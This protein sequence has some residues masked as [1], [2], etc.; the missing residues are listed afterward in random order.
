MKGER[1]KIG[2]DP[3]RGVAVAIDGRIT[4][5]ATYPGLKELMAGLMA[6][7][8][9]FPQIQEVVIERP[10][11][12]G[13]KTGRGMPVNVQRKISANIGQ[14][15]TAATAV[16]AYCEVQGVSARLQPSCK[17]LTKIKAERFKELTGYPFRCSEHGRDAAMLVF[18][19]GG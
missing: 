17:W 13:T 11:G 2:I 8:V 6:F 9:K 19:R 7:F 1:I 16:Q 18:E 15:M 4:E 10:H 14:V 12:L 3:P 5:V